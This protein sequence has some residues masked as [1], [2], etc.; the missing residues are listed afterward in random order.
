MARGSCPKAYP[1]YVRWLGAHRD[2][3]VPTLA[4]QADLKF[5]DPFAL[6]ERERADGGKESTR[7]WTGSPSPSGGIR[8]NADVLV[9]ERVAVLLQAAGV[10]DRAEEHAG[11]ALAV[12]ASAARERARP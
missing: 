9:L 8:I 11:L 5:G 10:L 6:L 3:A 4:H 2:D 1:W 12:Q 7:L